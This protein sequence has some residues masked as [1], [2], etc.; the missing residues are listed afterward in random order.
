MHKRTKIAILVVIAIVTLSI[1]LGILWAISFSNMFSGECFRDVMSIVY[2]DIT[3]HD[4]SKIIKAIREKLP[5]MHSLSF[6]NTVGDT[7]HL[8]IP[9]DSSDDEVSMIHEIIKKMENVSKVYG[10]GMACP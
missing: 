10:G 1:T 5:E 3:K 8:E 9:V 2:D 7:V 6:G 4:E